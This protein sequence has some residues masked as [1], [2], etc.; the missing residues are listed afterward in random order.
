MLSLR[1]AILKAQLAVE[2]DGLS[3]LGLGPHPP[4]PPLQRVDPP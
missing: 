3:R 2:P 4:P 1:E